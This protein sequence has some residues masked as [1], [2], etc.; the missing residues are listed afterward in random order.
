MAK[1][2][3][4]MPAAASRAERVD[5]RWHISL[6]TSKSDA[7][8][9]F[10]PNHSSTALAVCESVTAARMRDRASVSTPYCCRIG[11]LAW[12][13]ARRHT[14]PTL[15]ICSS[16]RRTISPRY[17]PEMSFSSSCARGSSERRSMFT[18]ASTRGSTLLDLPSSSSAS[19]LKPPHSVLIT[20]NSAPASPADTPVPSH[21][22]MADVR[23]RYAALEPVPRMTPA[24]HSGWSS[25]PA[26]S[27]PTVSL[28]S[29]VTRARAPSRSSAAFSSAHTSSP[30]TPSTAQ[31]LVQCIRLPL[32]MDRWCT[33]KEKVNPS[34]ASSSLPTADTVTSAIHPNSASALAPCRRWSGTRCSA[35]RCTEQVPS[36][37]SSTRTT[38]KLVPP[39]SSAQH[40]RFIRGDGRRVTNDGIILIDARLSPRRPMRMCSR[41]VSSTSRRREVGTVRS[42][43]S[44]S[45]KRTP[46][47]T[48]E[49]VLHWY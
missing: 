19:P 37:R 17:R 6:I 8:L 41:I 15:C 31:S 36:P 48:R 28:I 12:Y 14:S 30:T 2:T 22:S 20:M 23:S 43:V 24:P 27:V 3:A 32:L 1:T 26:S 33:G 47:A 34:G 5:T 9:P 38:R 35:A 40:T 45:R 21:F 18:S 39:R 46:S 49:R 42:C 25:A 7:V 29:A 16:R 11:A 44:A 4:A 10:T 13:C